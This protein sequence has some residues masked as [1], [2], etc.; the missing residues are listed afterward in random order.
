MAYVM[1]QGLVNVVLMIS[2]PRSLRF[3]PPITVTDQ[4]FNPAVVANH[5]GVWQIGDY[6]ALAADRNRFDPLWSDT[7]TGRLELVTATVHR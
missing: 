4:P 6:R 3:A 5:R 7:R 1:N 2:E